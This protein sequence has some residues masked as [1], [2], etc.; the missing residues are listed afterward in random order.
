MPWQQ[1][2]F[3][4]LWW[5]LYITVDRNC[6]GSNRDCWDHSGNC[7]GTEGIVVVTVGVASVTVVIAA[8][9]VEIGNTGNVCVHC[10][11]TPRISVFNSRLH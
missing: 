8:G 7:C 5:E 1:Q 10:K 11:V 6:S 3:H 2:G 9:T 4:R